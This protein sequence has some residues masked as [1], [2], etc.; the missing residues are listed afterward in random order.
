VIEV[1][2]AVFVVPCLLGYLATKSLGRGK[3]QKEEKNK[4]SKKKK[5]KIKC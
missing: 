3:S 5:K 1:K 2:T 4:L